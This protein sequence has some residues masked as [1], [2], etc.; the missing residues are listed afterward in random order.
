ML[1]YQVNQKTSLNEQ[2]T[3]LW[4]ELKDGTIINKPMLR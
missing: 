4:E 2:L 1:L 3:Y